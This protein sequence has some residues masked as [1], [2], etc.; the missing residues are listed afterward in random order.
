MSSAL[1][2]GKAREEERKN[3]EFLANLNKQKSNFFQNISHE[4]QSTVYHLIFYFIYYIN[5]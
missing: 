4:L 5:M 2:H 1:I 3:I